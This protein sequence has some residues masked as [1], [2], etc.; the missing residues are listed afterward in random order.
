[1][2][3]EATVDDLPVLIE[4]MEEFYAK[5]GYS[6]DHAE[7][8]A[9]FRLVLD[10]PH[11]GAIWLSHDDQ[12]VT[13]YVVLTVAFEM[14]FGGLVGRIDDLYVRP[15]ERRKGFANDLLQSLLI[16]CSDRNLKALHVDVAPDNE[17]AQ[18]LYKNIGLQL[19]TDKRDHLTV[20]L[21]DEF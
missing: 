21:N 8:D 5:S 15:V 16:D 1:M 3:R 2:L 14:E 12:N 7:A 4:M 20:R 19:R 9:A 11:H 13:G 10:H 17:A 18:T 6:L